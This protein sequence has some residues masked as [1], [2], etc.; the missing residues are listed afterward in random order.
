[1]DKNEVI[2]INDLALTEGQ[3]A[4]VKGGPIGDQVT[5]TYKVTNTSSADS[6]SMGGVSGSQGALQ[7]VGG[8]NT[9]TS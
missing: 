8:N 3:Q 9:W 2:E 7:N 6:P 5:W 4:E 1:M